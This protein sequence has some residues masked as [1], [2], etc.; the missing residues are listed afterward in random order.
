L[1]Q[2]G[3]KPRFGVV[4]LA[5]GAST[6]MGIGATPKQLL[7]YKGQTLVRRAAE[8]ALASLGRPVVVVLG[9]NAVAVG[10]ELE[11]PVVVT[12]N[13]EWETGMGSS[14][15]TGLEAV[16]AAD[17][18]VDAIVVMLCDQPFVTAELIDTLI[19]RRRETSK[20]IVVTEYGG[21]RGVPAL[22]A[23][24]LFAELGQLNGPEGARQIIRN[25]PDDAVAV[26]FAEAAIDIDTW[27]DY[28]ALRVAKD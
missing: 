16:L 6:R 14:I 3:S 25:H 12:R 11:L 2:I 24:E 27:Q 28:E 13:P 8:T 26:S 5:A 4:V 7:T 17:A 19:E 1:E 15:R 10:R 18:S 20:T 21:A 23:R 9:A 22:F